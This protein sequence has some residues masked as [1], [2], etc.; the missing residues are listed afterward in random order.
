M[1]TRQSD[2][3]VAAQWLAANRGQ[4]DISPIDHTYLIYCQKTGNKGSGWLVSSGELLTNEHVVKGEEAGG[5]VAISSSG[6]QVR[7]RK[8]VVDPQRDL[9]ALVP[10]EKIGGG[11]S[12]NS[13]E[14]P[15]IGERVHAWG[16]PFDHIGPIPLFLEGCLSGFRS[17]NGQKRYIVN[18]AFNPG[19]SGGPLFRSGSN[20]VIGVVVA[21]R[22]F[23]LPPFF[24]SALD[25]MEKNSTGVVYTAKDGQGNSRNFVESQI[26]AEL[27]R[28]YRTQTQ[29]MLGEAIA[30]SE[31][32]AFLKEAA[33]HLTK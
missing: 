17:H 21:K 7:M 2:T 12:L 6:A 8:C 27:L 24:E 3:L 9:A 18:G 11:L 16:F 28:F 25:A 33:Q 19:N 29:V 4:I 14:D 5:I 30:T 1:P 22:N 10:M 13:S 23:I 20:D 26:V 32:V 31:V 15:K